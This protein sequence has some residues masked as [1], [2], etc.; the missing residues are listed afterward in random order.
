MKRRIKISA[1]ISLILTIV[2]IIGII[3]S[4]IKII[5]WKLNTTKNK[6]IQEEISENIQVIEPEVPEE[7]PKYV[8]DFDALKQQNSDTIAY[9]KVDSTDVDYVVVKG[10]NNDYYLNHNF[11]KEYN[12]AGWIFADYKNKFDGTDKN[13]VIY[14]HNMQDESMFASLKEIL[15]SAWHENEK[16]KITLVTEKNTITYEIISSYSIEPE[17]Y[18]ITTE[19][20][21][22]EF[23]EFLTTITKRSYYDYHANVNTSD[24]ILTL[25]TC[26]GNGKN[27]IVIHAKQISLEEN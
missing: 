23:S 14:G 8:V 24:K 1:V 6:E 21:S 16:Q 17:E 18:Y 2:F 19:F 27:R 22:M 4:G 25:S 9:L 13:I 12:V 5:E 11:K 15:T 26:T 7:E 20:N 3:Y 10:D